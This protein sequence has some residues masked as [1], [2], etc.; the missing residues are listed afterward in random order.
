MLWQ[1]LLGTNASALSFVGGYSDFSNSTSGNTKTFSLTSLSGGLASAP[2]TGDIVIAC[3][4]FNDATDRNITCTGYTEV[5]DLYSNGTY[6]SQLGVFYKVL[7]SA[8]TSVAFDLGTNVAAS[9]CV[10]V[11]RYINSSPLDATST[12]ATFGGSTSAN[13]PSI[14][15]TTNNAIVL[16][17]GSAAAV[18]GDYGSPTAPSGM[19]NFFQAKTTATNSASI[20]IASVLQS[21]VGSYNPAVFSTSPSSSTGTWC[22]VTMALR[23]A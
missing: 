22:A 9:F 16:A 20:G 19:I 8:D 18:V 17:I 10:H 13:P 1:K 3:V 7:S 6:D 14:T 2:S 5:A 12:T 15:T 21:T 4:S 23:P 11:W